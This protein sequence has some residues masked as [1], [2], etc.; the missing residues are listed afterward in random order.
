MKKSTALL[1]TVFGVIIV[2]T[3]VYLI[4]NSESNQEI[5]K[6]NNIAADKKSLRMWETT[7]EG[8]RY[9]K[10]CIDGY[11]MVGTSSTHQHTQLAGPIG[12]C[13]E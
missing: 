1:S 10:T 2:F 6:R 3:G 4:V 12:K 8:A 5:V 13:N 9:F 11:Q 7:R